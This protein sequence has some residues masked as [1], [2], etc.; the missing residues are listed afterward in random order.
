MEGQENPT[1][2]V[3]FGG[4]QVV[5]AKQATTVEC[6]KENCGSNVQAN[7]SKDLGAKSAFQSIRNAELSRL[8]AAKSPL[9]RDL[10][11]KTQAAI[12]NAT[13][14]VNN[15][16]KAPASTNDLLN[17]SRKAKKAAL[18]D[19][20]KQ[21]KAVRFQWDE[22]RADAKAF[23]NKVEENRRQLLAVQRQI[24][25]AH[26][27]DKARK[28]E[29]DRLQRIADLDKE[30]EFN[31]EV[32]RDHQQKL[33]EERDRNRKK[34]IDARI[35][36][37]L[38]KCVG[39]EKLDSIRR[40]EEAAIFDV[41]SDL[42]R[43]RQEAKK[44]DADARRKSFQFRAGDA[45]RIRDI[46]SKWQQ[47]ELTQK[48]QSFELTRAAARDVDS[49]KKQ[50][51][52]ERRESLQ[53]RRKDAQRR[54]IQERDD[55]TAAM[56]KEHESYE[57]KWAGERDADAYH[58]KMQEERRKSLA[59]RNKESF[60]HAQVMKELRA[61]NIEK[62][63]ESFMLKFAADNDVKAYLKKLADERRESLKMRGQE[64]KRQRQY[65]DEQHREAVESAL[66]EG[67][68]QSECKLIMHRS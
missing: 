59:S 51:E 64:A 17:A 14:S 19:R 38:N 42:H 8:R 55:T 34:S 41:R 18:K 2:V 12:N 50:L 62:E 63:A 36:L 30:L 24:A 32:F 22:D 15:T 25:S 66:K 49:Y 1:P 46:R 4:T 7:D 57:L 39:E 33:K 16:L 23:Y 21:A 40:Q 26:F 43:A 29:A 47:E 27:Q 60:R 68:L 11:E 45:K 61:L 48:Q 3:L 10:A 35:K 37:R 9:R 5:E 65:E 28:Q 58:K 31:S 44:A 52:Q 54:R 67:I 6:E 56:N 20:S 53:N 13:S